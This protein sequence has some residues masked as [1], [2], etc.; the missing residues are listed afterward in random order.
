MVN[1]YLVLLTRNKQP[2]T[3][4]KNKKMA[5]KNIKVRDLKPK[6]DAKGGGG[7]P[8]KVYGSQPTGAVTGSAPT[9]AATGSAPTGALPPS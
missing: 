7:G 9:G 2:K 1:F 8:H 4:R 6:K 5:K 3:K